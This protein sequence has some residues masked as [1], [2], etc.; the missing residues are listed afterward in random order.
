MLHGQDTSAASDHHQPTFVSQRSLRLNSCVHHPLKGSPT[1]ALGLPP[2]PPTRHARA[3][4]AGRKLGPT[5][6]SSFAARAPGNR[7]ATAQPR[8]RPAAAATAGCPAWCIMP[9]SLS[10]SWT[11]KCGRPAL[12]RRSRFLTAAE[13]RDMPS[14]LSSQA[15]DALLAAA[16]AGTPS[17]CEQCC[18]SWVWRTW[19]CAP[20]AA[21]WAATRR[22]WWPAGRGLWSASVC[23]RRR[24]ATR[25]L[26]QTKDPR[27]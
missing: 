2:A 16:L 12:S 3:R 4:P 7:P 20:R 21:S 5:P 18:V 11:D 10:S 26:C 13:S 27:R 23:L 25:Q 9:P 17:A 6:P 24:G 19:M 14:A 8:G 1:G 22:S 15:D